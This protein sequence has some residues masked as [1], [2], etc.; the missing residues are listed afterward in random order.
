MIFIIN[1]FASGLGQR[2]LTQVDVFRQP[3]YAQCGQVDKEIDNLLCY[4]VL[5]INILVSLIQ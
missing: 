4:N 1:I 2:S 5:N 3:V